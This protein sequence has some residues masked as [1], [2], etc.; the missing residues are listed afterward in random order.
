MNAKLRM[1]KRQKKGQQSDRSSIVH[2]INIFAIQ[3]VIKIQ[4]G[5]KDTVLKNW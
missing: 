4:L 2:V 5:E 1:P 3:I